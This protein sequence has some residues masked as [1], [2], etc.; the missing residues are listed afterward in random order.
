[1]CLAVPAKVVEIDNQKEH[2]IVDY[3]D[4]TRRK[5]NV[6]LIDAKIGDYVLIHA[7]FAIQIIN[8]KDA[9]ATIDIFKEMIS[10]S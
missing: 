4:G 6:S 10:H 7:G 8:E 2:A 9:K 3:G 5:V 1:M